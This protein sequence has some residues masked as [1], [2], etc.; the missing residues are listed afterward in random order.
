MVQPYWQNNLAIFAYGSLLS[1][2]IMV[3]I[4][5]WLFVGWRDKLSW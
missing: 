1:A 2:R 4:A 3:R 5:A